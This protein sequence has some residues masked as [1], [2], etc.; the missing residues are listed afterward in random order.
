MKQPLSP[1]LV[2]A[3]VVGALALATAC[4]GPDSE[5]D[6]ASVEDR[7]PDAPAGYDAALAEMLSLHFEDLGAGVSAYTFEKEG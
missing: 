2:G 4:Q 7:I 3:F 5:Q 1:A 6:V